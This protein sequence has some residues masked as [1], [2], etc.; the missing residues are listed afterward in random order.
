METIRQKKK[1]KQVK[2]LDFY[3]RTAE[4]KKQANVEAIE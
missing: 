3:A 1:K 2:G 4:G